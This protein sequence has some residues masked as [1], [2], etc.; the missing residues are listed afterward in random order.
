VLFFAAF[1]AGGKEVLTTRVE[2]DT[3]SAAEAGKMK[4]GDKILSIEGKKIEDWEQLRNKIFSN[5]NKQLDI[6]VERDGAPVDLK[7]TPK[8]KDGGG[9]IG[10][11]PITER[12]PVGAQ[13]AALQSVV[14]PA[15]VVKALV[16]GLARIVTGKEKPQLAGPIGIVKE[17]GKAAKRSVF[18]YLYLLALLSAYLG[19]FNLVPFPALDG[20]RLMF[21]GYEAVT[22]RRPN[23]R[24]EAQI[25]A[26][27]LFLLLALILVVSVYDAKAF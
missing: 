14:Y 7:V 19:G 3:K 15:L 1:M 4:S 11:R 16:V 10:V 24:V 26:I 5:P 17:T 23:A 8:P 9:L 22:R 20:G 6:R 25:H 27:G 18:D 2:V 13:E 12:V 21:L